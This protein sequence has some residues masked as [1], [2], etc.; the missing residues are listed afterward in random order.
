MGIDLTTYYLG[1]QLRT[2]V[3]ASASPL[4]QTP[5]G[6]CELVEGGVGAVVLPSLF[7][8]QLVGADEEQPRR[9]FDHP[10]G[11]GGPERY[12][13]LVAQSSRAVD[14]PVIASLNGTDPGDWV[15]FG[16]E[17]QDAGA[18][19]IE[20]NYALVPDH[21]QAPPRLVEERCLELV[22]RLRSVVSVPVAVKLSPY[23]S[24]L[25]ELAL[26][27]VETGADG[28]VLFNRFLQARIDPEQLTVRP[29]VDLS[30]PADA[31]LPQTW[32]AILRE[33]LNTSLAGTGGAHSGADVA[34]YLLAGADVVMVAS[35]LLRNGRGYAD[36]L[37][38]ELE[39]WLEEKDLD[40]VS[41]ARGRLAV[42]WRV[43]PHDYEREGYVAALQTARRSYVGR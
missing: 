19:A 5:E 26:R 16:R 40:S 33:R 28:L 20:L 18:A 41:A 43:D 3:V 9:H 10:A 1:L 8:E 36:I 7:E 23:F 24:S 17:L 13:S 14:V 30:T 15:L 2:P 34:A 11:P 21:L 35:V 12:L 6:V 22:H 31:T 37:N 27:L 38:A 25:G 39:T 4:S 42:P 32:I 29:G